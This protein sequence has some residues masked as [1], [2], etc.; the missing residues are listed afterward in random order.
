MNVYKAFLHGD[1]TEEMHM[2]LPPSFH[3][4]HFGQV[5]HLKKSFYG[6]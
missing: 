3:T 1:L 4:S 2:K 6:L 5:C